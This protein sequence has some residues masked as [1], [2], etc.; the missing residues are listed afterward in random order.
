MARSWIMLAALTLGGC[1]G[2][3]DYYLDDYYAV[4]EIAE[5]S[6]G[7]GAA[8]RVLAT[9]AP[10]GSPSASLLPA[11]GPQSREPELLR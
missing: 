10:I 7:C 1:A 11:A 3:D 6:C 9:P 8:P 4:R 2:F 5:P